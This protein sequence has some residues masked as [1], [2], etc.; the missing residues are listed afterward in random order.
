MTTDD[1]GRRRTDDG[2]LVYYKL[3]LWAFGS[4]ELI[5]TAIFRVSEYLGNILWYI[6]FEQ[7][8]FSEM[9]PQ[10]ADGMANSIDPDQTNKVVSPCL[11]EQTGAVW[12]WSTLLAQTSLSKNF[13]T[14]LF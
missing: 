14:V 4:G 8:G 10:N 5:I 1:D 2:P 3:T 11:Q 6:R 12:S 9:C 13:I 7:S